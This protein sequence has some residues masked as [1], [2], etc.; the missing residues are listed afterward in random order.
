[1]FLPVYK[2]GVLEPI[3]F[4]V[5]IAATYGTFWMFWELS[6]QLFQNKTT[7]VVLILALVFPHLGFPGFQII[8]FELLNRSFVLPFLLAGILFY[9]KRKYILSLFIIGFM[10][11]FHVIYSFFVLLMILFDMLMRIKHFKWRQLLIAGGVFLVS[12]SPVLYWRLTTGT[13]IDL[14]LRPDILDVMS[15]SLLNTVYYPIGSG[16][17]SIFNFLSGLG[18]LAFL[19]LGITQKPANLHNREVKHFTIA[20][21]IVIFAASMASYFLPLTIVLQFQAS[22]I[23][24]FLL[25]FG[26]LYFA[27][28]IVQSFQSKEISG[29][30]FSILTIVYITFITPIFALVFWLLRKFLPS[31]KRLNTYL[32]VGLCLLQAGI[33]AGAIVFSY[34]S[35]G[36]HIYGTGSTWKDA[37]LWAKE[38]TSID[39]MFITPPDKFWHYTPDWRVFSERSSVSTIPEIMVVHLSPE[40]FVSFS[41]RFEDVAPGAMANFNSNYVESIK[42]TRNAYRSLTSEDYLRIAQKYQAGFLVIE[43]PSYVDFQ[44]AYENS[45]Y[46]IYSLP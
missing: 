20:I 42:I 29:Y 24:V 26:Y 44:I 32:I 33:L 8:E 11:N 7:N 22:R 19:I 37:Q 40:S 21:G 36:F 34:F 14:T 28:F 25:Y 5:H 4:I 12:A 35:P 2:I 13:G 39:T 38:N 10:F 16:L 30:Q 45:D 1:M 18:T 3:L 46:I 15:K 23:G 6:Q 43:K 17:P 41:S 31:R 9:L 27:N